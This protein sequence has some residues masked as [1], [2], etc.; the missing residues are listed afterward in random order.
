MKDDKD[1]REVLATGQWTDPLTLREYSWSLRDFVS[2]ASDLDDLR[3]IA[4]K[5]LKDSARHQLAEEVHMEDLEGEDE[6]E[7]VLAEIVVEDIET[8][9]SEG[10]E[11]L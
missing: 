9:K 5:F 1:L 10:F 8:G 7:R 2:N 3:T 6:H 4:E 11:E